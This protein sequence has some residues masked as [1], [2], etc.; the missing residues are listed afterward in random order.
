L[1]NYC[2]NGRPGW[3]TYMENYGSD[4]GLPGWSPYIMAIKR[5]IC[6]EFIAPHNFAD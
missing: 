1:D 5:M 4:G 3:P 6:N 2:L